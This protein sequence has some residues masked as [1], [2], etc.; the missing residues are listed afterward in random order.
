MKVVD[1]RTQNE[2]MTVDELPLGQAYLDKD[3][4]LCIKT[5]EAVKGYCSCLVYIS[6]KWYRGEEI[7]LTKVTPITTTLTVED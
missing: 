6:D 3:G 7:R 5:R 4:Y 1:K 2:M